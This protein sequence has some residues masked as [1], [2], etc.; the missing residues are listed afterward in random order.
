MSARLEPGEAVGLDVVA[1][2]VE[3]RNEFDATDFATG[4]PADSDRASENTKSYLAATASF[5]S[6]SRWNHRLELT[7]LDSLNENEADG[8]AAGSTAAEKAGFRHQS[9]FA[10]PDAAHAFTF[11]LE[12][13]S[14]R[15]VQRGQ[16]S[17]FGDPNQRQR[18]KTTGYVFEYRNEVADALSFSASARYDT[19]S[20][21]ESAATYRLTAAHALGERTQL[22]GSYGTGQKSPTFVERFGFF[23]D[24]FLGNPELKPEHSEGWEIGFRRTFGAGRMSL[25][26]AYFDERLGDEINGFA[27]DAATGRFTAVNQTGT[28]HR[29]GVETRVSARL[30]DA[31]ELTGS[32]AYLDATEPDGSGGQTREVRRPR[33]TGGLN[34]HYAFAPRASLNLN[35][36]YNGQ[37]YDTFFPPS[38]IAERRELGAYRLVT[39][40]GR[41]EL[42]DRIELFGRIENLLDEDYEDV[43]GFATAGRGAYVGVRADLDG[44]GGR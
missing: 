27:F 6:G 36:A 30:S 13:E 8:A 39:L 10:P 16:A 21:F 3:T 18:L 29:E 26:A 9:T 12:H 17:P 41:A 28:S 44:A 11:A 32:Y 43:F 35:V 37:R 2:R 1:R 24:L 19:S 5:D 31:L 42:T 7:Y 14:E 33:H 15:F 38:G 25:D 40:A 22:R 23:P 4:L 34:L 20:D